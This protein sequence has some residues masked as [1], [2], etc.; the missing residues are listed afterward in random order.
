MVPRVPT[1]QSMHNESPDKTPASSEQFLCKSGVKNSS[2][3]LNSV[4]RMSYQQ[5]IDS[6]KELTSSSASRFNHKQPWHKTHLERAKA[7]GYSQA[8]Q[9]S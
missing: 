4:Q 8:A 1:V 5:K 7:G 3:D 9:Q 6:P 2:L